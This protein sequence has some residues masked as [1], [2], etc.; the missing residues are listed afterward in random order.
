LGRG[1]AVTRP[2]FFYSRDI[3]GPASER[4]VLDCYRLAKYYGRN[5]REFLTMPFSEIMRHVMW[6]VKLQEKIRPLDDGD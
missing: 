4:L 3:D 5:P 6:T 2:P 1:G